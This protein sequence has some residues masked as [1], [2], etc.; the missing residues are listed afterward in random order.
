VWSRPV[1]SFA[2]WIYLDLSPRYVT[3]SGW[4]GDQDPTFDGLLDALNNMLRSAWAKAVSFGSDTGGYRCCGS[5][6]KVGVCEANVV[7][8][9]GVVRNTEERER[10]FCVGLSST[11]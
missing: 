9:D 11:L 8:V 3:F 6:D 2:N 5:T 1:D 7:V 10:C 4:V